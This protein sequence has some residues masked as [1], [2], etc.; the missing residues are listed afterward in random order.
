M[1]NLFK[2]F[3][4]WNNKRKLLKE[5]NLARKRVSGYTKE[6]KNELS[7]KALVRIFPEGWRN[8]MACNTFYSKNDQCP[9]CFPSKI[10]G[11]ISNNEDIPVLIQK[12]SFMPK[13]IV[14]KY[15][16]DL[17]DELNNGCKG[18]KID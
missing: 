12:G 2:I 10:G 17:L 13:E 6:Q 7:S 4:N 15:G 9:R 1:F 3:K 18:L 16:K 8:C 11:L 5:A 14:D